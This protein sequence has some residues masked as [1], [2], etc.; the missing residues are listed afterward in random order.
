MTKPTT[1]SLRSGCLKPPRG[2][3]L[4]QGCR[5]AWHDA[6][7]REL[8]IKLLEERLEAPLFLR[9]PRALA[10]TRQGCG[11]RRR[12]SEAFDLLREAFSR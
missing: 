2:F 12:T 9:R 8:Q 6:G 10:L 7:C 5:R 4:H 3:E 11:S 1:A